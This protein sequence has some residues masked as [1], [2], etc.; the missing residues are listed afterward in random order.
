[1]SNQ[2]THEITT[3]NQV[4]TFNE[5]ELKEVVIKP[6][7]SAQIP[8]DAMTAQQV[9]TRNAFIPT[10]TN[11]N[12]QTNEQN[13]RISQ[14]LKE[15]QANLLIQQISALADQVKQLQIQSQQT[16]P[17]PPVQQLVTQQQLA[18]QS[19]PSVTTIDMG[20]IHTALANQGQLIQQ[21]K[22]GQTTWA[23]SILTRLF[24]GSLSGSNAII[25]MGAYV[26]FKKLGW[27]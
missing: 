12:Q 5:Q 9:I 10:E 24:D 20:P 14:M 11:D 17:Q 26:L 2:I 19:Q 1:M 15:N 16:H 4:A 23:G 7:V 8:L 25:I 21:L 3:D 6:D 18:Q 13:K 27:A 22:Q